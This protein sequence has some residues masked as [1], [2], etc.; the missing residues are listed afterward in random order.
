[1]QASCASSCTTRRCHTSAIERRVQPARP[2][3][4]LASAKMPVLVNELGVLGLQS[5]FLDGEI[6]V[7]GTN[8]AP[9]FNALQNAFDRRQDAD[10]IVFFICDAPFFEGCD[11]REVPLIERRRLLRDYFDAKASEC[12]KPPSRCRRRRSPSA[13]TVGC[14]R[15][16]NEAEDARIAL[17]PKS[18]R[19]FLDSLKP[20]FLGTI[21]PD[22]R[23][24]AAICGGSTH[25]PTHDSP[26]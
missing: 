23:S 24:S 11:L 4:D 6:V 5:T 17:V 14:A 25:S 26:A 13:R 2:W 12:R 22:R 10:R 18:T 7:L 1:M 20:E 8:G 9:D 19:T 3:S 16:L 15:R 21:R